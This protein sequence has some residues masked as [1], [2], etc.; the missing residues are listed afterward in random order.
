MWQQMI[1]LECHSVKRWWCN[2]N[3]NNTKK[4]LDSQTDLPKSIQKSKI[5]TYQFLS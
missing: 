3:E 2:D 4:Y 1:D 5:H